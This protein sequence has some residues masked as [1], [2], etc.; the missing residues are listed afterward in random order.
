MCA[1]LDKVSAGKKTGFDAGRFKKLSQP[2]RCGLDF[3]N[4][5][6]S[7]TR[8]SDWPLRTIEDQVLSNEGLVSDSFCVASFA[9][10]L[11]RRQD[12]L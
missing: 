2:L 9:G 6:H 5:G 3:N 11:N 4:R 8:Q 12:V 1:F 7:L 10:F